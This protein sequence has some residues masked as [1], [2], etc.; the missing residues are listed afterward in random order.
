MFTTFLTGRRGPLNAGWPLCAVDCTTFTFHRYNTD[1]SIESKL[2]RQLP[3]GIGLGGAYCACSK[4]CKTA[5]KRAKLTGDIAPLRLAHVIMF[6]DFFVKL[7]LSF[8]CRICCRFAHDVAPN[9][10][11]GIS[12]RL[13]VCLLVF[14]IVLLF[15]L[16]FVLFFVFFVFPFLLLFLLFLQNHTHKASRLRNDL[17]CVGWGV[18]LYSITC[19]QSVILTVL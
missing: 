2:K 6:G 12:V 13:F 16:F 18:K 3:A 11:N 1:A 7:L 9:W 5:P 17:Y 4:L 10:F 8:V 14:L 15:I 19:P